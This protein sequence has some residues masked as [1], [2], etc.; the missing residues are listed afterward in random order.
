MRE[1]GDYPH[2]G[3][4]ERASAVGLKFTSSAKN[5]FFKIP[6]SGGVMLCKSIS[7]KGEIVGTSTDED[8]LDLEG[9]TF[10]GRTCM[11]KT[12]KKGV[13]SNTLATELV[14]AESSPEVRFSAGAGEQG[15]LLEATCNS[16]LLRVK[17]YVNAKLTS[18]AGHAVEAAEFSSGSET[19]L[20]TETSTDNGAQ[21]SGPYATE[22][23]ASMVVKSSS[24][25][26]IG[27]G[28][29]QEGGGTTEL[30]GS[31]RGRSTGAAILWKKWSCSSVPSAAEKRNATM[32]K[33]TPTAD[34]TSKKSPRA[35]TK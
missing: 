3:E 22:E 7:G 31:F 15:I 32:R 16:V 17:G 11:S 26:G 5:V 18:A 25:I 19:T 27:T 6:S 1:A 33:P 23:V 4:Y 10:E 35:H 34:M 29:E 28:N 8:A 24:L 9:C 14:G 20:E 13:L 30:P 21:W 2:T 12:E